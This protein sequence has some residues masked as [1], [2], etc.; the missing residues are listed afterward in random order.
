MAGAARKLCFE[1]SANRKAVAPAASG[2]A[3][4]RTR[5]PGPSITSA[6][7]THVRNRASVSAWAPP[8]S[9]YTAGVTRTAPVS[10]RIHAGGARRRCVCHA[11]RPRVQSRATVLTTRS[12]MKVP[13]LPSH[14][15]QDG[16]C[17]EVGGRIQGQYDRWLHPA[18]GWIEIGEL[19]PRLECRETPQHGPLGVVEDGARP[20]DPQTREEEHEGHQR[21]V[22]RCADVPGPAASDRQ[23]GSLSPCSARGGSVDGSCMFRYRPTTQAG[24]PFASL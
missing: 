20:G 15:I 3:P 1:K 19:A 7:P 8:A 5:A 22:E 24:L 4:V 11:S 9:R 17:H 6:I 10:A 12:P 14:A 23:V 16:G 13:A 2:K 21:H 18:V